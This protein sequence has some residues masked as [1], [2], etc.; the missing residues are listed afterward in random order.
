M[1]ELIQMSD[2]AARYPFELSGGQQQR[3]ALARAMAPEPKVLLLDEPFSNLDAEL[4]TSIREE[5]RLILEKTGITCLFASHDAADLEVAC[6][7]IVRMPKASA[8]PAEVV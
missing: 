1:L 8:G 5:M 7:R 4:K 3:V 2:L 6:G